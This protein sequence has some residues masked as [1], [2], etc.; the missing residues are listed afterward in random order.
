[1]AANCSE[2]LV[3]NGVPES[4]KPAVA[5]IRLSKRGGSLVRLK[6][7]VLIAFHRQPYLFICELEF[8]FAVD[9]RS[10]T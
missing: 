5:L 9:G 7:W 8:N 4:V 6:A 2:R 3:R 1:M 10:D